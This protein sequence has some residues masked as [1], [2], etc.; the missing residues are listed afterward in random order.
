MLNIG[1]IKDGDLLL[2]GEINEREPGITEGL[3]SAYNFD[4]TT[5][6]YIPNLIRYVRDWAN[7]NNINTYNT[8]VEMQVID[9]DN[10]NIARNKKVTSNKRAINELPLST[11]VDNSFDNNNYVAFA[12][13]GSG[14][15]YVQIDLGDFYNV[16]EIKIWHYVA[17]N[18]SYIDTKT[19][20]SQD[21][22]D[23][24]TIFDSRVEGQYLETIHGKTISLSNLGPTCN[25]IVNENNTVRYSGVTIQSG[26]T[27][28]IPN[29]KL[30]FEKWDKV[31][32][33]TVTFSTD[34]FVQEWLTPDAVRITTTGGTHYKKL[35]LN[36][37]NPTTNTIN[38]TSQV[39]I[40]NIGMNPVAFSDN[41]TGS[42]IVEVGEV[43]TAT[44]YFVGDGNQNL[45]LSFSSVLVSDSLDFLVY[46]PQIENKNYASN[47]VVGSTQNG[48]L[49]LPFNLVPPFSLT[50]KHTGIQDLS[51]ID[52]QNPVTI[53]QLGRTYGNNNTISL[54]NNGSKL[55]LL[56]KGGSGAEWDIDKRDI[57]TFTPQNWNRVEHHYSIVCLKD[58]TTIQLYLD[59]KIISTISTTDPIQDIDSDVISLG[60][61]K[62]NAVYRDLF[63]YKTALSNNDVKLLA[64]GGFDLSSDG[65]LTMSS[66]VEGIVY[67]NN[68]TIFPLCS[69][70]TDSHGVF[71]AKSE[72]NT[73]FKNNSIWVGTPTENLLYKSGAINLEQ[74]EDLNGFATKTDLGFG[75]YLFENNG[76]GVS[77]IK[78]GCKT[79]D[80]IPSTPYSAQVNF[81]ENYGEI[82]LMYKGNKISPKK[83]ARMGILYGKFNSHVYDSTSNYVY[84]ELQPNTKVVL[85]E[86]QVEEGVFVSPF[87]LTGR[88]DSNLKFSLYRDL[89]LLW[90]GNWSIA[91]WKKPIATDND[92]LNGYSIDSLGCETN[93]VGGG[94][95]YWGKVGNSD[96]LKAKFSTKSDTPF[97]FKPHN[98]VPKSYFDAWHM[99]TIIKTGSAITITEW[100]IG[101]QD[102]KITVDVGNITQNHFV[103]QGGYDLQLGGWEDS[104]GI[105]HPVN[106]Y[107]RD[108]V[109]AKRAFTDREISEMLR[110]QFVSEKE[111]FR[112]QRTF[113]EES[114]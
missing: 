65:D 26:T 9:Q 59:G 42:Y 16:K 8:W 63:I 51:T 54:I 90:N 49:E 87:T 20:V 53:M 2:Y 102:H 5:Q 106:A 37:F 84:V 18:R 27:N 68:S 46:E 33:A 10:I 98:I 32:G 6:K 104:D 79:S 45:E 113:K 101:G 100:A 12:S 7:G 55:C 76:D 48:K 91:Y 44:L 58:K 17:D 40:K 61:S 19:Q 105:N 96:V 80:L 108:L 83:T 67:P 21:G 15:A 92:Y 97:N 73:A 36:V 22:V 47:F 31:D 24:Y 85:Y 110:R 75:F 60:S 78:L 29:D 111:L 71:E 34:Q 93:T 23:W 107:Y 99:V 25:P 114:L 64:N 35:R 30:N 56:V 14:P 112:I 72:T 11:V 94:Y 43:K 77:A 103:T 95:S 89:G 1:K 81:I 39:K 69:S 109:V 74:A 62:T 70:T 86:D 13:D 28:L 38:Y 52:A 3:V 88:G 82:R 66:V 50:F 41:V 57:F 4:G